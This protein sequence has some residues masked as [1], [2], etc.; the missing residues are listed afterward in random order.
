M[1]TLALERSHGWLFTKL[2]DVVEHAWMAAN[3]LRA[4]VNANPMLEAKILTQREFEEM[5]V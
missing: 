3:R 1:Q 4:M 2:K 5:H